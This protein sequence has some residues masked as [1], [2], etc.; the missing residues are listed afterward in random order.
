[1]KFNEKLLELRKK[2]GLSQEE[3]GR[4]LNVSR[5]TISKW[6]SGQSYPDFEK[7]VLLSDFFELTLDELMKGIDVQEIKE[8]NNHLVD[9]SYFFK[10]IVNSLSCI[11][12]VIIIITIVAVILSLLTTGKIIQP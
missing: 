5:Q 3:L 9:I 12:G 8:K 4:E 1:M 11:G 2:K 7:L 10:I 6:E